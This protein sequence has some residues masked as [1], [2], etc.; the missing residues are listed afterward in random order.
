MPTRMATAC[1]LMAAILA[2]PLLAQAVMT[3]PT[4]GDKPAPVSVTDPAGPADLPEEIA[5]DSARDLKDTRFYNKPGATR[6]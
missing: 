1:L 6:A 2:Q 4:G 5:K 3:V